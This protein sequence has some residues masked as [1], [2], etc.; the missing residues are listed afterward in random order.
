MN[1]IV[2]SD[3]WFNLVLSW[4]NIIVNFL[5]A[6]RFVKIICSALLL[7]FSFIW[8]RTR[9]FIFLIAYFTFSA[10]SMLIKFLHRMTLVFLYSL[11]FWLVVLRTWN[12]LLFFC[13]MPRADWMGSWFIKRFCI[14]IAWAWSLGKLR[15]HSHSMWETL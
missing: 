2:H 11:E 8:S 1:S 12:F 5:F 10:K 13:N 3:Q 14:V 7:S 4:A 9:H 15:F 6:F